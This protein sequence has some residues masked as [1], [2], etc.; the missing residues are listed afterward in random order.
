MPLTRYAVTYQ[1]LPASEL[2]LWRSYP[3]SHISDAMGR[4]RCVSPEIRPLKAGMKFAGHARTVQVPPGDNA[5]VHAAAALV[6][7]AEVLVI[8]AGG[9][10]DVA[11]WGGVLT[12]IARRRGVAG[13]VLD[14]ATRDSAEVLETG[15]PLFCRAITPRSGSKLAIGT[16]DG[17]IAVGGVVVR[18]GDL[19]VGD[20]DGVVVVPYDDI[21]VTLGKVKA[22]MTRE[23]QILADIEHG[24]TS[25]EILGIAIP[26]LN[27][28]RT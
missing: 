5:G 27:A 1:P 7:Q 13:V 26:D 20:D 10:T 15:F 16:I 2:E 17:P 21:Q 22:A 18:T 24:R 28:G 12:T 14:G 25:A 3:T 4:S 19:V 6:G 11:V 9:F 23:A 8:D